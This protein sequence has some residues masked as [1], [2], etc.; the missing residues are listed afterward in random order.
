[1]RLDRARGPRDN[2]SREFLI[3]VIFQTAVVLGML[4]RFHHF[5]LRFRWLQPAGLLVGSVSLLTA[6]Y[7]AMSTAPGIDVLLIPAILAFCWSLLAISLTGAFEMQPPV[8][9]RGAG[10]FRRQWVRLQRALKILV[11]IGFMGLT[12]ALIVVSFQLIN[13]GLG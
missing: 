5:A 1:M 13:A 2:G 6:G 9:E 8:V 10:F 3:P 12:V 11:A 4:E 7:A